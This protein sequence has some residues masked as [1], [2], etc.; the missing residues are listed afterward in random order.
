MS[1]DLFHSA[2][3]KTIGWPHKSYLQKTSIGQTLTLLAYS[4]V[5]PFIRGKTKR[6]FFFSQKCQRGWIGKDN[7]EVLLDNNYLWHLFA[8]YIMN[9]K[10]KFFNF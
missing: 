10:R 8:V 2:I 5:T 6:F 4:N 1:N 7:S 3:A 9:G